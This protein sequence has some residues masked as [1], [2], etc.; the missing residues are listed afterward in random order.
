MSIKNL[1][2]TLTCIMQKVVEPSMLQRPPEIVQQTLPIGPAEEPLP[3]NYANLP[4][5]SKLDE[6]PNPFEKSFSDISST[7]TAP[8]APKNPS[9]P[10]SKPVLPPVTSMDSPSTGIPTF[11]KGT[12]DQF[13]WGSLRAG[14]L[15][16]SMLQGPVNSNLISFTGASVVTTAATTSMKPVD[17]DEFVPYQPQIPSSMQYS[18]QANTQ[19][20]SVNGTKYG[21]YQQPPA[22]MPQPVKPTPAQHVTTFPV[23]SQ[24]QPY[25]QDQSAVK[26][27]ARPYQTTTEFIHHGNGVS[28]RKATRSTNQPSNDSKPPNRTK[29]Q[30]HGELLEGLG[31]TNKRPKSVSSEQDED[32][33]RRNFLERNRQAALKCRQRKKAWLSDLQGKVET[34]SQENEQL[35]LQANSFRD[36]IIHLKSLLL[37]HKDCRVANENESSFRMALEKPVPPPVGTASQRQE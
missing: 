3:E 8:V 13:A 18:F 9:P 35:A 2:K 14:P 15:S 31:P 36:E 4:Q 17:S 10:L 21:V 24:S 19:P 23:T 29:R 22:P 27:E 20:N 12:V 6:E 28:S 30:E 37:A 26:V 5:N 1:D 33:K 7:A 16:P 34:L 32:E 25:G 11:K